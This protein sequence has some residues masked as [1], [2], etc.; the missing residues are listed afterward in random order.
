MV[1]SRNAI[2][3]HAD[4]LEISDVD[5]GDLILAVVFSQQ[6]RPKGGRVQ[7]GRPPPEDRTHVHSVGI[8][9]TRI[10][11]SIQEAVVLPCEW[12]KLKHAE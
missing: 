10:L 6:L 1:A 4:G 5:E 2:N 7:R 12:R 9:H 8:A 11:V 3:S